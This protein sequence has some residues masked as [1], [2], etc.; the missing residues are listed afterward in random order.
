[1]RFDKFTL[2]A[3]EA[4]ATAQQRAMG[5]GN[6]IVSSLHLLSSLLE[7]AEGVVLMVLGRIGANAG[8]IREIAEAEIGRLPKS[9]GAGAGQL[10]PEPALNQIVLDAQNRAAYSDYSWHNLIE[11]FGY[12]DKLLILKKPFDNIEVRQIACSLV[13]KWHL[14]R[15]VESK[16]KNLEMLVDNLSEQL[17]MAG[18]LQRDFLPAK[19][20]N[21]DR[22]RWSTIFLPAEWAS[23]D[24][25]DA[26]RIDKHHIGF[27]VADVVGHGVPAAILAIF[28]KQ[29]LV[30]CET[31]DSDN[32]VFYPSEVMNNLNTRMLAQQLSGNPFVTCCY[33]LLNTETLELTYARSGHPHPILIRKGEKPKNLEIKGSLLGVFEQ[34]E[35]PQ[36]T[37]QLQS[38]DKLLLY[39]DGAESIIMDFDKE[40]NSNFGEEFCKIK[41]LDIVEMTKSLNILARDQENISSE[42]DDITIIG[43][44]VL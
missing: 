18:L 37:V 35:Y 32:H 7:D 23:G 38:G 10:M 20:P 44:E 39:S 30:M 6:T 8:R 12:T 28:F 17:H 21:T 42:I 15:Q 34:P 43:F 26:V 14:S 25:Y 3:Q 9:A 11:R 36:Q 27:Y 4:L 33:C 1:M 16:Q 5:N 13:E 22:I 41:D 29:I 24:I 31:I 19:L 2:K 40:R